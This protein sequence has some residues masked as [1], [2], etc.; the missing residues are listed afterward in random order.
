MGTKEILRKLL[1]SGHG[2]TRAM[3]DDI[4]EEESIQRGGTGVNH[5]RWQTGHLVYGAKMILDLLKNPVEFTDDWRTLFAGGSTLSDNPSDYPPF[6]ILRSRLY[7]LHGQMIAALD[8]CSDDDLTAAVKLEDKWD[9]NP[10]DG[11][12]FLSQHDYYHLGQVAVVRKA[13]GRQR[14]FG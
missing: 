3:L 9:T 8:R 14:A 10:V 5:I 2:S 7:E 11:L 6:E 12:A 13:L 1:Q 4:T